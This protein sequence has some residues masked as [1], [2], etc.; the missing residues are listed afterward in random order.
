MNASAH[1]S[2]IYFWIM[3]LPLP[4]DKRYTILKKKDIDNIDF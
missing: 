1:E 3:P 4:L 2:L